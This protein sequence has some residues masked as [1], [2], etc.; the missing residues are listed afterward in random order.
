MVAGAANQIVQTRSFAA[1]YENT[2]AGEVELVIVGFTALVEAND[3]EVLFLQLFKGTDEVDYASQAEMLGCSRAGLHGHWAERRGAPLGEDNSVDTGT[4][5]YAEQGAEILRVFDA[6]EGQ[7]KTPCSGLGGREEIFNREEFLWPNK[8]DN[9]LVSLRSG[10]L[11]ELLARLLADAHAC[12]TA[13]SNEA[14]ETVVLALAGDENV[15]EAA[16]AGAQGFLN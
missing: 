5:G 2:V 11:R 1:E 12:F 14:R 15:I 16:A 10:D 4:V 7:N 6:V 8:G 9:A 13:G 3:P